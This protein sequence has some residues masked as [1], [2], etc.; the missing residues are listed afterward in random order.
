MLDIDTLRIAQVSVGACVFVLVYLGTYRTTRAPY[1]AWWSGA[2][3]A[4]GLGSLLYLPL[5]TWGVAAAA[6]GNAVS[7]F[8]AGLVWGAARALRNR[9]TTLWHLFPVPLVIFAYSMA[10]S[11]QDETLPGT[12]AL[13]LGMC[14]FIALSARELWQILQTR[15]LRK[16]ADAFHSARAAVL[17]MA[18]A[19]TAAASFYGLRI[20]SYALAGPQSDF[21]LAWTGPKMTTLVVLLLLVVVTYS[22]TELSHFELSRQWRERANHDDL[23]GL[24][25]RKAFT[26]LAEAALAEAATS[27][28]PLVLVAADFDHFKQLNDMYGHAE[29]DRALHAF[30]EACRGVLREDD[31]AC[32]MGGEEFDLLLVGTAIEDAESVCQRLNAAYV[33]AYSDAPDNAPTVSYGVTIADP[34]KPWG[35]L[36]ARA[37]AALYRAKELGRDRIVV[38]A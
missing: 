26:E 4:S 17:S 31:L 30:G 16:G 28:R 22:V 7:V 37:D 35:A 1:A 6:I 33:S 9:A 32:R 11:R 20:V 21:Y 34:S 23:T 3:L 2:V 19:S 15:H 5:D 14:A 10:E 18:V 12:F 25:T 13:L 36:V 24:L 29:G 38:D 8:G 27:A